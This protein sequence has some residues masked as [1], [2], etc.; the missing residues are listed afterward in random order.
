[1][2][3]SNISFIHMRSSFKI[4]LVGYQDTHPSERTKRCVSFLKA[5]A[6]R[7]PLDYYEAYRGQVFNMTILK[8]FIHVTKFRTQC[9]SHMWV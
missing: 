2:Q 3:I 4:K 8:L 6:E 7:Y 9:H 5:S 1:M